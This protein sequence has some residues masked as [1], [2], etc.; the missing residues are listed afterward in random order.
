MKLKNLSLKTKVFLSFVIL[1]LVSVTTFGVTEIFAEPSIDD[2]VEEVAIGE[3]E[4]HC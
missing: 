3:F 1:F 4:A 2:L